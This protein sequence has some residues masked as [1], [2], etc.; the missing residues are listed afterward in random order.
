[1]RIHCFCY[2]IVIAHSWKNVV[3]VAFL[4]IVFTWKSKLSLS[5]KV[6][7]SN[8]P[9][10]LFKISVIEIHQRNLQISVTEIHK[11]GNDLESEIMKGI[12]HF[13]KKPYRLRNYATLQR[14]RNCTVYF[15]AKSIFSLSPKIWEI[16]P[17][18]IK[19]A[20][21]VDIFKEKIK[22]WTTDKWWNRL[23]KYYIDNVDFVWLCFKEIRDKYFYCHFIIL[24][25]IF[26]IIVV[27][28][29][30]TFILVFLHC[31]F[32]LEN[33]YRFSKILYLNL[34]LKNSVRVDLSSCDC[35]TVF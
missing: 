29:Y 16:V 19:N 7:P 28:Y 4:K 30:V 20:K 8:L 6:S 31:N 24:F 11:M 12:F 9:L 2:F 13:I 34:V 18:K 21:S 26:Y 32:F 25:L 17:C 10:S 23:C 15:G 33:L 35:V 5:S 14:Q 1:M 22:L 3:L 27:L